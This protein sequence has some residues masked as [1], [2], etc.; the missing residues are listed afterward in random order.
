[1]ASNVIRTILNFVNRPTGSKVVKWA[2]AQTEWWFQK[3]TSP[4]IK[5]GKYAKNIFVSLN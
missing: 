4:P 2:Q 5:E 1:L 3:P